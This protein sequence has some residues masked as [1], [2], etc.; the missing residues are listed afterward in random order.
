MNM[1]Y[2]TSH[3]ACCDFPPARSS[4]TIR[5]SSSDMCVKYRQREVPKREYALRIRLEPVVHAN[6]AATV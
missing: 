5:K 1:Q 4:R 6:V 3:H 2:G